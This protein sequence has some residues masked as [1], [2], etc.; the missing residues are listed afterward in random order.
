MR[1]CLAGLLVLVAATCA[2]EEVT[3]SFEV[4]GTVL[5]Q[6]GEAEKP[7]PLTEVTAYAASHWGQHDAADYEAFA[8][9]QGPL[10][11]VTVSGSAVTDE[12]GEYSIK[13]TVTLT[14][15]RIPN[16]LFHEAGT[17]RDLP[18]AWICLVVLSERKFGLGLPVRVHKDSKATCRIECHEYGVC[19][20]RTVDAD[21]KPIAGQQ[22]SPK[23]L[24]HWMPQDVPLP[25]AT[26]AP[27]GTFELSVPA[28]WEFDLEFAGKL[29]S[30]HL[31]RWSSWFDQ[32]LTIEPL[33]KLPLRDVVLALPSKLRVRFVDGV[34]GKDATG[35]FVLLNP[36]R[37]PG[38][39]GFGQSGTGT[40]ELTVPVGSYTMTVYRHDVEVAS[41]VQLRTAEN[42]LTDL[43]D[44]KVYMPVALTVHV[45]DE[46][47]ARFLDARVHLRVKD[48]SRLTV[49][50]NLDEHG[51]F[52]AR[53]DPSQSWIMQ[54]WA[55]GMVSHEVPLALEPK[56]A[57]ITVKLVREAEVEIRVQAVAGERAG[58]SF[59]MLV[60][61]GTEAEQLL[62]EEGPQ[63]VKD[64]LRGTA[65]NTPQGLHLPRGRIRVA[66]GN[67]ILL[68]LIEDEP[69][70]YRVDLLLAPGDNAPVIIKQRGGSIR[71]RCMDGARALAGTEI[72]FT[73]PSVLRSFIAETDE[74]G[75]IELT[76]QQP[77]TWFLRQVGEQ[78]DDPTEL[79]QRKVVVLRGDNP[80]ATVDFAYH[81]ITSVTFLIE[82]T[83]CQPNI[84]H[85]WDEYEFMELRMDTES[86]HFQGS[87]VNWGVIEP[88]RY[89]ALLGH[90]D[91]AQS[92]ELFVTEF[93]VDGPGLREV[94]LRGRARYVSGK[95]DI[96]G[97]PDG[98]EVY[99]QYARLASDGSEFSDGVSAG[100]FLRADPDGAFRIPFAG[101]CELRVQASV[102]L[103]DGGAMHSPAV[104]VKQGEFP[105][106]LMFKPVAEVGTLVLELKVPDKVHVCVSRI[107]L[108]DSAGLHQLIPFRSQLVIEG[109]DAYL[110]PG[111]PV[112]K[113][114]IVIEATGAQIETLEDVEISATTTAF[115]TLKL[116]RACEL[117]IRHPKLSD[118]EIAS[119]HVQLLDEN[120]NVLS[121]S[122][123]YHR[124]KFAALRA[125]T[126]TD[127]AGSTRVEGFRIE[128]RD[129]RV[130]QVR[131]LVAGYKP[132]E[133]SVDWQQPGRRALPHGLEAK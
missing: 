32:P 112:G 43:G 92:I 130:A 69:E 70:Y 54:V 114:D 116:K 26:S 105:Q 106:D 124:S 87:R 25:V 42:T 71:I 24:V 101:L 2:A 23:V 59:A 13:G 65:L 121:T 73:E 39:M 55:E 75:W 22:V 28:N 99:V 58:L 110:L 78:L 115:R 38:T 126:F 21:G 33:E 131:L 36:S 62:N 94:T 66:P 50:A 18:V 80:D 46:L 111:V 51:R 128:A 89:F 27:D 79:E 30:S 20:G 68:A 60:Q 104:L 15:E 5:T 9:S 84:L 77:G 31:G 91:G 90:D 127:E 16:V 57:E 103:P 123:L 12:R 49:P 7:L 56:D 76:E 52:T 81:Y 122:S 72:K 34:S 82:A 83:D 19:T 48:R 47:G 132:F 88:G 113:W 117:L 109:R 95:I 93:T 61:S 10:P 8:R 133:A 41:G 3:W 100:E 108:R 1:T 96:T 86:R 129:R 45:V 53:L 44:V 74:N 85:I 118:T 107:Q 4:Q 102:M 17:A 6:A 29:R 97:L 125:G 119:A 14:G 40:L 35:V 120:G 98:A 63:A 37:G 64:T 11:K 67:W